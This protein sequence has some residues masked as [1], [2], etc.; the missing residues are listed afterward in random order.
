M[1]A[2]PPGSGFTPPRNGSFPRLASALLPEAKGVN[3]FTLK[4]QLPLSGCQ[5]V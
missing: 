5:A 1:L 2:L 3:V 4:Q